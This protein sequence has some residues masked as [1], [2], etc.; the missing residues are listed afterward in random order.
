MYCSFPFGLDSLK[1]F[2]KNLSS[3]QATTLSITL[4]HSHY[5]TFTCSDKISLS[6]SNMHSF[7]NT[8]CPTKS[9]IDILTL[10]HSLKYTNTSIHSLCHSVTLT[11]CHSVTL[12]L[13]HSLTLLLFHSLML[14]FSHFLNT[15]SLT[16][17]IFCLPTL[18]LSHSLTL[19]LSHSLTF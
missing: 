14:S 8:H 6:V 10:S 11:L 13:S 15:C 1:I 18:S 4:T 12:S 16:L 7:T 9:L 2:I 17:S 3:Y 5:L 19:L